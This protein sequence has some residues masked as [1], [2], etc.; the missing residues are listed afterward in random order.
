[1]L[2]SARAASRWMRSSTSTR[3]AGVVERMISR[4]ARTTR[5]RPP[6]SDCGSYEEKTQP[7]LAL[8]EQRG[9]VQRINGN[10]PIEAVTAEIVA[11]L[12]PIFEGSVG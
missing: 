12:S 6:R 3:R 10:Q 2:S 1:M 4:G 8:Y 9:I 11:A 7:L 5:A